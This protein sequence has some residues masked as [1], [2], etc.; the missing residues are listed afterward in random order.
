M[1]ALEL[2]VGGTVDPAGRRGR[3]LVDAE[4]AGTVVR[5]APGRFVR[6]HEWHAA[7]PRARHIARIEAVLPRTDPRLVLS[8]ASAAAV[9]DLPWPGEWPERVTVLDPS[10]DR[11]QTLPNVR[12]YPGRGRWSA[13][14]PT[15]W[16]STT[17][18]LTTA[19]DIGLTQPLSVSLPVADVCLA[20]GVV[21]DH[22]TRALEG[23]NAVRGRSRAA[24]MIALADARSESP[25]ESRCRLALHE[26]GAPVPELQHVFDDAAGV[27]ARVDFW[28][29]EHGVALEFDGAVKY[30]DRTLRSG[31]TASR[32]VLDEKRREDRLRRHPRV[33]TVVRCDA[34]DVREPVRLA[35][36]LEHVGIQCRARPARSL[37]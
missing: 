37:R 14:V 27:I 6:A 10:R 18:L 8:H 5:V 34:R 21:R 26:I 25:G 3:S 1:A 11:S 22:L 31:R 29:P 16:G 17:D 23:H 13:V 35:R 4:R 28:F 36:L 32:V 33:T 2:L 24:E 19:L 7:T 15:P 30:L 9:H 12:K 20:R